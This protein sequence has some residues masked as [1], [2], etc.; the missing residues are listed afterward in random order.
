MLLITY[1][2]ENI[3]ALLNFAIFSSAGPPTGRE[4][5]RF[6]DTIQDVLLSFISNTIVIPSIMSLSVV[7]L[8]EL[9]SSSLTPDIVQLLCW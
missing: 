2:I 4:I 1:L 6:H 3:R 5:S 9:V 7:Q 8:S